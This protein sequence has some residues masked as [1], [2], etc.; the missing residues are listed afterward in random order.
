MRPAQPAE[1]SRVALDV[2]GDATLPLHLPPSPGWAAIP[3]IAAPAAPEQHT[4]KHD[5][6]VAGLEPAALAMRE[7]PNTPAEQARSVQGERTRQAAARERSNHPERRHL[8]IAT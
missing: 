4:S 5:L 8:D 2:Q 6:L 3:R 7:P 1:A